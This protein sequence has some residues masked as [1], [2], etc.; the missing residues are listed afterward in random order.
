LS[1]FV[2]RLPGS[3]LNGSA[4][5]TGEDVRPELSVRRIQ[6]YREAV[7]SRPAAGRADSRYVGHRRKAD[8]GNEER[9]DCCVPGRSCHAPPTFEAAPAEARCSPDTALQPA[10]MSA[11]RPPPQL[12]RPSRAPREY[13]SWRGESAADRR[14][15]VQQS[16]RC[17]DV[18]SVHAAG[19]HNGNDPVPIDLG[20]HARRAL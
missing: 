1:S 7:R 11:R 13:V 2:C 18:E 8:D 15:A 16:E 3:L 17:K 5:T 14:T 10:N 9:K 4:G 19:S 20:S 6:R 12:W